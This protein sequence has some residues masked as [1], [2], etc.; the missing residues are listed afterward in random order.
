MICTT[1]PLLQARELGRSID[2]DE[3]FLQTHTKKFGAW[4]DSRSA[5][6]YVSYDK[7]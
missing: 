3:F 6:T 2:L 7:L 5:G 1:R 4:V